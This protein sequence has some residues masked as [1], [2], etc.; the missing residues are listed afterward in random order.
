MS[1]VV[2]TVLRSGGDFR[3]W[4]VQALKARLQETL[5]DMGTFLC[6]TDEPHGIPGLAS[7]PLARPDLRGW[8]AKLE[9]FSVA[10]HVGVFQGPWLYFDLDMLPVARFRVPVPRDD[11][12]LMWRDPLYYNRT[13]EMNSSVMAWTGDFSFLHDGHCPAHVD[14]FKGDQRYIRA[15]L[16][17][18]PRPVEIVAVDDTVNTVDY[19]QDR[20]AGKPL[21]AGVQLVGFHG[22]PRPWD[23]S[24]PWA[25]QAYAKFRP[26]AAMAAG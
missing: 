23:V 16:L 12:F 21:P 7:L 11:Q 14:M 10:A 1:W 13:G 18:A 15:S 25:T 26:R 22:K 6:L 19:K 5:E 4:H 2:L 3:P 9:A 17:L 8:W 20:L 24:D